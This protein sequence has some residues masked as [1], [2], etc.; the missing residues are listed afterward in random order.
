MAKNVIGPSGTRG[1]VLTTFQQMLFSGLAKKGLRGQ[2][3]NALVKPALVSV[4]ARGCPH[5]ETR[6]VD[7]TEKSD[8]APVFLKRLVP[9]EHGPR[10][11]YEG[12]C[13][14]SATLGGPGFTGFQS[15]A[16]QAVGVE[17]D[18]LP[19]GGLLGS[20]RLVELQQCEAIVRGH[21][22]LD[23]RCSRKAAKGFTR[24]QQH[25]LGKRSKGRLVERSE[26]DLQENFPTMMRMKQADLLW[27][28]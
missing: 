1:K 28:Y 3:A 27:H 16:E 8:P 2:G 18:R 13:T 25:G 14:H 15:N 5:L 6:W 19:R 4:A 20:V 7:V 12:G 24:C 10:D 26:Q 21:K 23:H 22:I 11:M 17:R 9:V